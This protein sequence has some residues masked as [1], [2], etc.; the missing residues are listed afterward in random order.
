MVKL[1]EQEEEEDSPIND[2]GTTLELAVV[3]RIASTYVLT[4]CHNRTTVD[5]NN[6]NSDT[7][8][9]ELK[10][11]SSP[12]NIIIIIIAA[13]SRPPLNKVDATRYSCP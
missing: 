6:N 9:V 3:S 10:L 5:D 11:S 2:P 13:S 1:S 4:Y 8:L 12:S 7:K